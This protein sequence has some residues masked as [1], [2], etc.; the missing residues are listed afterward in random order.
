MSIAVTETGPVSATAR[1]N[2]T[3]AVERSRVVGDAF[4]RFVRDADGTMWRGDGTAEPELVS[5]STGGIAE[6]PGNTAITGAS[7]WLKTTGGAAGAPP[8][9][10][11]ASD[12]EPFSTG[13]PFPSAPRVLNITD[14]GDIQQQGAHLISGSMTPFFPTTMLEIGSDL[15]ANS[16]IVA[17]M[18]NISSQYPFIGGIAQSIYFGVDALGGLHWANGT[19]IP[20]LGNAFSFDTA[21][22]REA[23]GSL[24]LDGQ[25]HVKAT[26]AASTTLTVDGKAGQSADLL[27]VRLSDGTVLM[28][29]NPT[30]GSLATQVLTVGSGGGS[31]IDNAMV[32]ASGIGGGDVGFAFNASAAGGDLLRL[33]VAGTLISSVTATGDALFGTVTLGD[34]GFGST[35]AVFRHKTN[36]GF[37]SYALA[38]D[39]TGKTILNSASAQPILIRNNNADKAQFTSAGELEELVAGNGIIMKSP[40]GTRY[41]LTIA[42]GGT[43]AVAAA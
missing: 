40:D 39:N 11:I 33:K 25:L 6:A 38:Q 27:N 5:G 30:T 17:S 7:P 23:A 24:L 16:A 36:T 13:S 10:L 43:T 15:G 9:V 1:R 2:P 12:W 35:F 26:A 21:L 29:I 32:S 20:A 4:D 19:A 14:R 3:D 22:T 41:R 18:A 34:L 28:K 37:S 8:R 42:N 31:R